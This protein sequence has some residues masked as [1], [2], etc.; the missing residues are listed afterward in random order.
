MKI[1]AGRA[2]NALVAEK[3]LG[4]KPWIERRGQYEYI[5]WQES[6]KREPW[7]D[8]R[9][10]ESVKKK[11]R[12]LDTYDPRHHIELSLPKFSSQIEEAWRVVQY[13]VDRR[14]DALGNK[15]AFMKPLTGSSDEEAALNICIAALQ[16]EGVI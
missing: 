2:T 14:S 3:V 4:W 13:Y 7:F 1:I 9:D 12:P 8:T 15:L 10:W 5:I 6:G 16:A 11:Y